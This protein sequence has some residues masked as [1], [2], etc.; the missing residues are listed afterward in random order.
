MLPKLIDFGVFDLPFLGET[1]IFL[2]TYGVVFILA[3]LSAW[4]WFGR[5][6]QGMG[7]EQEPL[8]NL[9]FYAVLAGILGAKLLL[10][11]IDWKLY[12]SHPALLRGVVRSAGVLLGGV[13]AGALTFV[14]YSRKHG[15]PTLELT[16]ALV[17][18]LALAQ[19]I[20]R[21]GCY[22]A[23][24]CWGKATHAGHPLA[25]T[26]T[27]PVATQQTGVPLHQPLIATQ[28]IQMVHDLALDALLTVLWRRRPQPAGTVLW[29]YVLLYSIGRGTIELWRGD[30]GRGMYFGD[31]LSTSQL[32]SLLGATVAVVMLLRG[33]LRN[34]QAVST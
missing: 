11:L 32:F 13:V 27:N 29:V 17:A 15:M 24:C 23:G 4:W 31:M 14:Y 19:S 1:P 10:V 7:I 20:G 22:A 2:P 8:F 33:R 21:I 30:T 16:D 18:P 3:L 25:I 9:L 34:R 12:L 28:L 6:A 26:F 5:R